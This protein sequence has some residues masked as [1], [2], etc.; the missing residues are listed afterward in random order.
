MGLY[1]CT[2]GEVEFPLLSIKFLPPLHSAQYFNL[3]I[4][5]SYTYTLTFQ[6]FPIKYQH[7]VLAILIWLVSGLQSFRLRPVRHVLGCFA[8]VS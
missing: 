1:Q 5:S 4:F 2:P 8:N 3:P 6:R 7:V